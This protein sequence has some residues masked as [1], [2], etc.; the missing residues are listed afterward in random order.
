[1][2]ASGPQ[3]KPSVQETDIPVYFHVV[4]SPKFKL[5][6]EV[7][8]AVYIQFHH[9][10]LGG[11]N[12]LQWRMDVDRYS[13]MLQG[14]LVQI[15]P[16]SL[17]ILVIGVPN[18]LKSKGFDSFWSC[19]L[20]PL[21]TLRHR[22][23]WAPLLFSWWIEHLLE[24]AS[25]P[26]R[27]YQQ[28]DQINAGGLLRNWGTKAQNRLIALR[29]LTNRLFSYVEHLFE[30][31]MLAHIR[32]LGNGLHT[33]IFLDWRKPFLTVLCLQGVVCNLLVQSNV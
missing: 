15:S 4:V 3:S 10:F 30:C 25:R 9:E 18:S 16:I 2:K 7:G 23:I 19:S 12:S 11:F 13:F 28:K 20:G 31:K 33:C 8:D 22:D 27:G 17:A 26:P 21:P 5:N 24:T 14:P 29:N 32:V 1:M 6:P